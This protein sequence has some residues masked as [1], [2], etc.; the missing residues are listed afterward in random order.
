M[1]PARRPTPR[2]D[3]TAQPPDAQLP[4]RHRPPPPPARQRSQN[5]CYRAVQDE[6]AYAHTSSNCSSGRAALDGVS[7][8]CIVA[9]RMQHRH[10]G[11]QKTP[12]R[13]CT[14]RR[15]LQQT[16]STSSAR[17]PHE[18]AA[19]A[20]RDARLVRAPACCV[21]RAACAGVDCSKQRQRARSC[22]R[23]SRRPSDLVCAYRPR[24]GTDTCGGRLPASKAAPERSQDVAPR[25]AI[26][27]AHRCALNRR[28]KRT[29]LRANQHRASSGAACRLP[30]PSGRTAA[31][32]GRGPAA[33]T[34]LGSGARLL[35]AA[36]RHALARAAGARACAR[37][38]RA[39]RRVGASGTAGS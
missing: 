21:W 27:Q 14:R 1:Q 4:P 29:P 17:S 33:G 2:Q 28:P 23:R 11:R 13:C 18:G 10:A 34:L 38:A 3:S 36:R 32:P 37:S 19:A 7:A 15:Q 35:C 5:S 8:C 9:A 22:M 31:A 24:P 30:R 25:T 26:R 39:R 6:K 20:L 12:Q 16:A